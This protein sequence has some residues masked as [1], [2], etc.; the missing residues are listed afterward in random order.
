VKDQAGY[1]Y[2]VRVQAAHSLGRLPLEGYR[3]T[4][5]IA[6]EFLRLA[7][8]M[9]QDSIKE[10][11]SPRWKNYFD[12]LYFAFNPEPA[13][14]AERKGLLGQV[15]SKPVL[16]GTKTVVTEAYQLFVPLAQNI[17]ESKSAPPLPDQLRKVKAWLDTRGKPPV[18][19]GP[20]ANSK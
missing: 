16:A 13:E 6:V 18:A 1:T 7:S 12:W 5:E 8:Q 10:P 9:A 14:K 17:F 19:A 15:D 4:D 11:N 3:K 20:V 2:R